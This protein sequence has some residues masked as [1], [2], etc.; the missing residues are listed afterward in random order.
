[1]LDLMIDLGFLSSCESDEAFLASWKVFCDIEIFSNWGYK[2]RMLN[3]VTF[4]FFGGT[5]VE[6]A[7][8][9]LHA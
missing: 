6:H 1:M 9:H 4:L 7:Y 2:A 8:L 5:Q 3:K